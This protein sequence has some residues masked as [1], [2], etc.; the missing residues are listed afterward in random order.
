[1]ESKVDRNDAASR[2]PGKGPAAKIALAGGWQ[3]GSG[4]KRQRGKTGGTRGS[5][6]VF[7]VEVGQV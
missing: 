5:R 6:T 2:A 4:R 7:N 3:G 1:M